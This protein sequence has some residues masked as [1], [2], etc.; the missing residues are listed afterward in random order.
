M[1]KKREIKEFIEY[2]TKS[3]EAKRVIDAAEIINDEGFDFWSF[4]KLILLEYYLEPYLNILSNQE[5]KCFFIDFFCSC[6]ANKIKNE[7][8]FSIGSPIISI[9]KGIRYIKSKDKNNRFYKWFFID[10]NKTFCDALNKRIKETIKIVKEN[11][12]EELKLN[13]DINILC[14]NCNDKID[15]VINEIEKESGKKAILVFIDPYTFTNIEW[16]TLEKILRLK[17]VDVIFTFPIYTIRRGYKQCKELKK[18]LPQKLTELL[19]GKNINE[20]PENEFTKIYAEEMTKIVK[21]RLAYYSKGISVKN[22]SNQEIYRI[23]LFTHS[24]LAALT[25]ERIV[26]DLDKIDANTLKKL[27][28]QIYGRLS[29]LYDFNKD[30]I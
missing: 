2:Y 13:K 5:Y 29:S 23:F 19:N 7:K 26:K 6:G 3:E 9:L 1:R 18:Y 17:Y 27:I 12:N 25:T 8:I 15:V 24:S 28:E 22:L 16:K 30:N 10:C 20:I 21:R 14:G 4:K 11:Y